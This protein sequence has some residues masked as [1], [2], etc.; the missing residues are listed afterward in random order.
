[1]I[2]NAFTCTGTFANYQLPSPVAAM[3][4]CGGCSLN[5]QR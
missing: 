4:E 3:S 5:S 1:M 2:D